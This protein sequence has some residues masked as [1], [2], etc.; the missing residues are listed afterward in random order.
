MIWKLLLLSFATT[1]FVEIIAFLI[2]LKIKKYAIID[3][4]W[5]LGFIAVAVVSLF[6]QGTFFPEQILTTIMV[7]F[8]GIRLAIHLY[9]R[10]AKKGEDWRYK[11]MI[12]K[13]KT[14][15]YLQ[16]FFRVFLSQALLMFFISLP[17]VFINSKELGSFYF[18]ELTGVIVWSLGFLTE[19]IA[20]YQLAK[21]KLS[22]KTG[23]LKTGLWKYSRHPNY[24]GEIFCWWGIFIIALGAPYGFVSIIGP[25][26]ITYL[27]I[28]VSG[29]PLLEEKLKQKRGYKRY[30]R[31]TGMLFPKLK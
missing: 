17:I 2:S 25:I 31:N 13:Y 8:W 5:G 3:T 10:L 21:F 1:I 26:F 12:G 22:Q 9:Y 4:F 20:D 27:I 11:Q 6:Y 14:N 23:I 28:Y 18:L 19:T 30:T 15:R 29:I 16:I 7:G 24:L